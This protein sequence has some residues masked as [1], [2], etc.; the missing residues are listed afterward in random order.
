MSPSD[1]IQAFIDDDIFAQGMAAPVPA[2]EPMRILIVDGAGT[3]GIGASLAAGL[4][5]AMHGHVTITLH[6]TVPDDSEIEAS[7]DVERGTVTIGGY[8]GRLAI[9]GATNAK[10]RAALASLA[11][12]AAATSLRREVTYG[13]PEFFAREPKR[14]AQWKSEA[15]G[16]PDQHCRT[17][18]RR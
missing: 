3:R 13:G 12:S 14:K 9:T 16:R 8:S 4:R 7:V 15:A 2:P 5:A 18:K 1:V 6:D 17:G 11:I 10:L